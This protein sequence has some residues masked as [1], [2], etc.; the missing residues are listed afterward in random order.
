MVAPDRPIPESVTA[1][2]PPAPGATVSRLTSRTIRSFV[3]RNGRLTPAQ[4]DA[5]NR[6]MPIHGV[7]YQSTPID[8]AALFG[9]IAPIWVEIGFG[10]GD[11]LLHMAASNPDVNLL[12][13]EVHAP[14][15]GHALLGVE[16]RGLEN[17]RII[18]HD[19]LDVL[20]YMLGPGSLTRVLL[21]FADPWHKKR[22]H[23]RRIVQP[24]FIA[25]VAASL[26]TGG[27]LHCATD[28]S[29]YANWMLDRL[30]ACDQFANQSPTAS[31]VAQPDWRPTTRFER[32]GQRL[33][34]TVFDLLYAR[35]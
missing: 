16:A 4:A 35:L 8:T 34:H 17:V 10:N 3:V 19:A 27:L 2:S 33:G 32:R 26:Q 9:R 14:G 25:S 28:W 6:L 29:D 21:F 24:Q 11:A 1:M 7:E 23:K 15:V 12:G 13:I 20:Q 30:N 5:M 18:R 31:F 22:H